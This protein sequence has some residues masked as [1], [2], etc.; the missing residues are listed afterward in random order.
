M[1]QLSDTNY[2][3]SF[4]LEII[5]TEFKQIPKVKYQMEHTGMTIKNLNTIIAQKE[6]TV[7]QLSQKKTR[8]RPPHEAV[9]V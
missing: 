7:S 5:I 1:S 9:Q 8:L 6:S 2:L 3:D 4:H